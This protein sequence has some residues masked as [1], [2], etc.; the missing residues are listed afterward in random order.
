MILRSEEEEVTGKELLK[1]AAE[2]RS[3]SILAECCIWKA[4]K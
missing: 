4:E 1:Y 3:L 2:K